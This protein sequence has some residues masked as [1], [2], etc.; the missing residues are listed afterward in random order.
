MAFVK[1]DT[2]DHYSTLP[3]CLNYNNGV[4]NCMGVGQRR[5]SVSLAS[6]H[7]KQTKP[8]TSSYILTFY[9]L[10]F[11]ADLIWPISNSVWSFM[12]EV[13]WKTL[14]FHSISLMT[15]TL[16]RRLSQLSHTTTHFQVIHFNFKSAFKVCGTYIKS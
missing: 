5:Q 8:E 10:K 1:N 6:Y 13:S 3:T 4:P 14:T 9:L 12:V 2:Q 7:L 11:A 16:C 15:K